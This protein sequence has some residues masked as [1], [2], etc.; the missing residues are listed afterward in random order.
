[1]ALLLVL[2]LLVAAVVIADLVDVVEEQ[3]NTS[4]SWNRRVHSCRNRIVETVPLTAI[5]I[6]LVAWQILTQV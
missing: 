5:K 2:A 3:E 1:M 6:V 4:S